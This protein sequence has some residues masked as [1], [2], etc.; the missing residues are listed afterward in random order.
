M[1]LLNNYNPFTHGPILLSEN[2]PNKLL[3][4]AKLMDG[5]REEGLILSAGIRRETGCSYDTR[6]AIPVTATAPRLHD[7]RWCPP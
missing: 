3:D 2:R 6:G 5:V 4:Y 7:S 1:L